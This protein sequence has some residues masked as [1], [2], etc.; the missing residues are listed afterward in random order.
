MEE[1][2]GSVDSL[3][4]S[5]EARQGRE[6]P[7]DIQAQ[8][9]QEIAFL[10]PLV[11]S[12]EAGAEGRLIVSLGH[13]P[14]VVRVSQTEDGT[15]AEFPVGCVPKRRG[16]LAT[17]LAHNA[18]SFWVYSVADHAPESQTVLAILETTI[19]TDELLPGLLLMAWQSW[20]RNQGLLRILRGEFDD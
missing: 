15:R 3:E 2:L 4:S 13:A 17:L 20:C 9:R 14:V 5:N 8:W 19:V 16:A 10:G 7:Q 1:E 6:A 18:D 11:N 12:V